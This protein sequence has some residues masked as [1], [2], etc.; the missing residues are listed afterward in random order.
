M[1]I[2]NNPKINYTEQISSNNGERLEDIKKMVHLSEEQYNTL[3]EI[4]QI[5]KLKKEII[6]LNEKLK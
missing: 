2:G 5:N 3:N 1:G 4:V 6:Y